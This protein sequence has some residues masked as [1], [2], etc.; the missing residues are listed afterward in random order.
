MPRSHEQGMPGECFQNWGA[1]SPWPVLR[2]RST[3]APRSC[4][5]PAAPHQTRAGGPGHLGGQ[6]TPNAITCGLVSL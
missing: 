5:R 3:P 4:P 6:E 2:S 1:S